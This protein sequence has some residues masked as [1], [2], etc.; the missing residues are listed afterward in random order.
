MIAEFSIVPV[1]QGESLSGF[2]AKV[3]AIVEKSGLDYQL[4]AMGTL[5]EGEP[6]KVLSLLQRC[7]QA[8]RKDSRR[9]LTT[10]RIDDRAAA[11]NRLVAKVRSVEKKLGRRASC[12]G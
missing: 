2:V 7:H 6:K 8:G 12:P 9:I 10:I 3:L 1:G 5:V 4:T 11:G